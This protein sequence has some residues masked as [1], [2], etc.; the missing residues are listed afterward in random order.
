MT[1]MTISMAARLKLVVTNVD[2]T[3]AS[4]KIN[5]GIYTLRISDPFT[6]MDSIEVM[7]L[8]LKKVHRVW[9]HIR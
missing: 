9:P 6:M 8:S 7:V 5:F 3:R 2:A 4:G 1:S